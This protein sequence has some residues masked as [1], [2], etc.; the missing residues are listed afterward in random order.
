MVFFELRL[1]Y[2]VMEIGGW[3]DCYCRIF[4]GNGVKIKE[5]DVILKLILC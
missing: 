5:Y 2:N 3:I 4:F 1:N